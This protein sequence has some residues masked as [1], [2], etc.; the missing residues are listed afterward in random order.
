MY[1]VQPADTSIGTEIWAF[2]RFRQDA[3]S[4][5]LKDILALEKTGIEEEDCEKIRDSLQQISVDASSIPDGTYFSKA[6]YCEIDD[7]RKAYTKWNNV[8]GSNEIAIKDRNI[9]FEALKKKRHKIS[10]KTRKHQHVLAND[11]DL[12]VVDNMYDSFNGLVSL[13]PNV[14]NNLGNAVARYHSG[15]SKAEKG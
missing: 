13:L 1:H 6:I 10:K 7:F 12:K 11:L 9:A 2:N 5:F 15:K 14:F 8:N 4:Q 3:L